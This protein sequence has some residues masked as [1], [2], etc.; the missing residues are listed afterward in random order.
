MFMNIVRLFKFPL[1]VSVI[2]TI[3]G[4]V[5][6]WFANKM[7]SVDLPPVCKSWNK[8]FIMEIT[9]FITG[10]LTGICMIVLNYFSFVLT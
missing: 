9:L 2:V 3:L 7:F 6:S 10:F 5:T 4:T 8:N 1:I